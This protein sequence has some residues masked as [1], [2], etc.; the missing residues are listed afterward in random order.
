MRLR[1]LPA[2]A[3]AITLAFAASA[4]EPR[5]DQ[6][7]AEPATET[8]E[9]FPGTYTPAAPIQEQD[10]VVGEQQDAALF[11]PEDTLDAPAP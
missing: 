1:H 10:Q 11:P 6:W 7:E 8:V 9:P 5:D 4:C 3:A 2:L